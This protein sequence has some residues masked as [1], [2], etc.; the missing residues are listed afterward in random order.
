MKFET[1]YLIR[2]GIPG[3]ILIFWLLYEF[4]FLKGINPL[5]SKMADIKTRLTLLLSLTAIRCANRLFVTS[6]LFW[7]RMGIQ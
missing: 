7:Y 4:L 5:D 3:W 6:A 1:K 2:W